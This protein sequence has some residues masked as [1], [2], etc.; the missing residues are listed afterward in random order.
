MYSSVMTI[1]CTISRGLECF[2]GPCVTRE[3]I[4]PSHHQQ[5]GSHDLSHSWYGEA[6]WAYPRTVIW[7]THLFCGDS[8]APHHI[9][10]HVLSLSYLYACHQLVLCL[11]SCSSQLLEGPSPS[12]PTDHF[13]FFCAC[14]PEFSLFQWGV[15]CVPK[16][17][18]PQVQTLRPHFP[19]LQ[20]V[21]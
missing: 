10:V 16:I 11:L 5:D 6:S 17:S 12:C 4:N 2:T 3:P 7:G 14:M 20:C 1:S 8:Q 13:P 18:L 15:T 21:Q 9:C 19:C